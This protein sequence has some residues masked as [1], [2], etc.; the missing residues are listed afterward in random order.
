MNV[1]HAW[2][3][4]W[5][6]LGSRKHSLVR[7]NSAARIDS[8][9]WRGRAPHAVCW[10]V[11]VTVLLL[12]W[13]VASPPAAAHPMGNFS[14][15][16]FSALD[17]HPTLIQIS[18]ILDLA[19]IPTFQEIQDYGLTPQPAHP[20]AIAYR[21]RKVQE[22]Q[23]GLWVQLGGQRLPLTV[24]TSTIDFPPGAGGLPTLRLAV[25]YEAPLKERNG[26]LV[27]EDRNYPQRAGWKEIVATASDGMA[28]IASSVPAESR[29]SQLTAYAAD[30]LQAPPQD[31]R[32]SL[33][34]TASASESESRP[35]SQT[36]V[37][38]PTVPRAPGT[39]QTP[40][41]MVTEL[42]TARQLSVGVIFFSL[43]VAIGL[44]AFHALEPGHGKT[45]V[46]AY[47][48]GSQ[49]TAWHAI[50][51]GLTVTASHTIGVYILGGV[52]LFASHY[53]FPEQLY[54][55]L[56]FT[57]GLL[58]AGMGI[59][60]LAHAWQE[61]FGH[62][63]HSSVPHHVHHH[64]AHP[65]DHGHDDAHSHHNHSHHHHPSEQHL[66]GE[67]REQRSV[68]YGTLLTLGI[69]GGMI[70]CPA[71]LVVL[72][73]A[74]AL[75]RI[76]FGLLLIVAFSVGLAVVLVGTG[77]LLVSARGLVQRWSGD[78]PWLT[79]VPFLSPLVMTPLGVVIAIRSLFGA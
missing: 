75:Q 29:S 57:S 79:Y 32:A 36:R 58:I 38:P 22:L 9:A 48:V 39:A 25:V 27:Y 63:A 62:H 24:R 1:S 67:Q 5:E 10:V 73:S 66:P 33:S 35:F 53:V 61:R 45:L 23:Q 21:E 14:I 31:L 59:V 51:L 46:A 30:L 34:F 47:L 76:A 37:L 7:G 44:G 28:L 78:G 12:G 49:G 68:G 6:G 19:E 69:T 15:N 20:S 52:A 65:H 17:V 13:L 41:S 11:W 18:Y 16:H 72:L 56:G 8:P 71:A 26:E 64:H 60:M 43:L 54:P 50:I 74:V 42:I 4:L 40:R 70:P 55:W 2:P 3:W 77:L